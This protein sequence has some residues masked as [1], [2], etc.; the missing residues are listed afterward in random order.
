MT[1]Y[2]NYYTNRFGWDE[3]EYRT[4][5]DGYLETAIGLQYAEVWDETC[6]PEEFEECHEY[7]PDMTEN[8]K[9]ALVK[10]NDYRKLTHEQMLDMLNIAF[11]EGVV[12]GNKEYCE[13][14]ASIIAGEYD[15]EEWEDE[16]E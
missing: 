8:F 10:E 2:D 7:I 3:D 11:N 14:K 13:I 15:N 9:S 4:E 6:M 5:Y 1:I 12:R 16:E